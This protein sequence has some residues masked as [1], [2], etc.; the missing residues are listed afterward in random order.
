M[1]LPTHAERKDAIRDQVPEHLR[2]LVRTMG[3][4]AWEHPSRSKQ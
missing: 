2:E 1:K 3:R 4:I